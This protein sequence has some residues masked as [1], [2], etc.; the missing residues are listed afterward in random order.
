MNPLDVQLAKLA[1]G[2]HSVVTRRQ[3]LSLGMTHRQVD[4]RVQAGGF[5]VLH[6]STYALAGARRTYEQSLM[7]ACLATGGVASHRAAA[8]LWRLR[9]IEDPPVEITVPGRQRPRLHGVIVHR[10]ALLVPAH[11]TRRH[12]IP[13]TKPALTILDLGAVVPELV[14]GA[15]EDALFKKLLRVDGLR[16]AL[17]EY[18]APGRGGTLVLRKLLLARDPLQAPT[19]SRLEDEIVAVLR[20][21]GLPEPVRQHP[22][23][24]PGRKPYR[25]DISYPEV[26]VDIEGN[27]QRWHTSTR[28]IRR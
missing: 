21:F 26:L 2:Q 11:V 19:E 20:R 18:G 9:G 5:T 24:R 8:Y 10:S 12:G 28:D 25:L 17:A 13:V 15:A 23:P 22:V 3:A 16:R 4:R 6:P 27:G 14:E 1:A 7:A